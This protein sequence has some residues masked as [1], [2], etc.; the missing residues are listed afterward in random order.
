MFSIVMP[1]CNQLARLRLA[2]ANVLAAACAELAE[3]E[4]I[5]VDDADSGEVAELTQRMAAA[6]A[7]VRVDYVAGGRSGRSGARNRGARAARGSQLLFLDGDMLL[8]AG[9]LTEHLSFCKATPHSVGRGTIYRL[10]W[11]RGFDDPA[12]QAVQSGQL[13]GLRSRMVCLDERGYPSLAVTRHGRLTRFERDIQRWFYRGDFAARGRWLGVTGAHLA[14]PR[15]V[16]ERL[17]GFDERMGKRWGAEDLE[18]GYRL[19][20]AGVPIEQVSAP[21]YH[22]DHDV[23]GRDGDHAWALQ[24]FAE[25]HQNPG[26]VG[27]LDYFEGRCEFERVALS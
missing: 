13:P 4:L 3:A 6:S 23:A 16:F 22:M 18:L 19:E 21:A 12:Q 26:V 20:Q 2:L 14:V 1:T 7:H 25:K 9:A 27:L 10:P 5:V 11:L 8:G 17:G 24:Y 15:A